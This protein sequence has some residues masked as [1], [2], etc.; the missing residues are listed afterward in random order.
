[1]PGQQV[2]GDRPTD[3]EKFTTRIASLP[4]TTIVQ[5]KTMPY[6]TIY[7]MLGSLQ[8]S[9]TGQSH[10]K[11]VAAMFGVNPADPTLAEGI[12]AVYGQTVAKAVIK[13]LESPAFKTQQQIFVRVSEVYADKLRQAEIKGKAGNLTKDP[14]KIA[15]MYM[16]FA[17]GISA[18]NA[19]LQTITALVQ[20][21]ETK[22]A[23]NLIGVLVNYWFFNKMF[24]ISFQKLAGVAVHDN[25]S[26]FVER[27]I[28][29]IFKVTLSQDMF[30][31][32][33]ATAKST[34]SGFYQSYYHIKQGD[35]S[36]FE[37]D[38]FYPF[39]SNVFVT[40]QNTIASP[41]DA[42]DPRLKPSHITSK[43]PDSIKSG[44]RLLVNEL[45][46]DIKPPTLGMVPLLFFSLAIRATGVTSPQSLKDQIK[47]TRTAK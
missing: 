35:K 8:S 9:Q 5:T 47:Q 27:A 45:Q 25:S 29:N 43:A 39:I 34:L 14:R 41:H 1:M 15:Y 28:D 32:D 4:E 18:L 7:L 46:S 16:L 19:F 21:F 12:T 26:T 6:K 24:N 23:G 37:H 31:K 22:K 33:K 10:V 30:E 20:S 38:D 36:L 44:V 3:M 13:Q 40:S 2:S 42:H 11:T 17:S